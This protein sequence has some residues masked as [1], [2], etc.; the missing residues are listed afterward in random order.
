MKKIFTIVILLFA[1]YGAKAQQEAMLTQYMFTGQYHNPAYVGSHPYSSASVLHR[2]Q[3][4]GL[5]GAPKTNVASFDG[6]MRNEKVGLGGLII[7]DK[8]GVTSRLDFLT[9]YSYKLKLSKGFLNLGLR[10]GIGNYRSNFD[11]LTYWDQDNTFNSPQ[12]S[13]ITPKF[14]FGAYYY[15]QRTYAGFS[16]PTIYAFD[17]GPRNLNYPS[18]SRHYFLT[19]GTLLDISKSVKFRP[20][21]LLKYVAGAPVETDISATFLL[22][23]MLWVGATYR[24]KDAVTGIIEYQINKQ[25]RL[26][27][28]YDYTTSV[29]NPHVKGTHEFM[30]AVDLVKDE[31][32]IRNPRFF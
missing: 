23:D 6:I 16:I 28:A 32:K 19:A 25:I 9:N 7:N 29:I 21:F 30:L 27:Y 14:G 1:S 17:K 20:S 15:T 5:E 3:W 26:G 13:S 24:T 22:R 11:Q 4:V 31:I 8:I 10:A 18:F 12:K 2:N